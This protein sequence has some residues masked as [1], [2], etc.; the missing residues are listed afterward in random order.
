MYGRPLMSRL[1]LIGTIL[2]LVLAPIVVYGGGET[3]ESSP[4]QRVLN[5]PSTGG[6][7]RID[8]EIDVTDPDNTEAVDAIQMYDLSL[9]LADEYYRILDSYENQVWLEVHTGIGREV[10]FDGDR[11]FL[12]PVIAFR[13]NLLHPKIPD[14]GSLLARL[15]AFDALLSQYGIVLEPD[16]RNRIDSIRGEL[17]DYRRRTFFKRVAVGVGLPYVASEDRAQE[18]FPDEN[19]RYLF[20]YFLFDRPYFFVAY[21]PVDFI[22]AHAGINLW[23]EGAFAAVTFDI[24]TPVRTAFRQFNYWLERMLNL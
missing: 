17:E 1:F 15:Y 8:Y 11:P 2:A 3:E 14:S 13:M 5:R 20:G 23:G 7:V 24:S 4:P 22:S 18:Y 6:R 12:G 16:D 10:R 9:R 19:T 21:D